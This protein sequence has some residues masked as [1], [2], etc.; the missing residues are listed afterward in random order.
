MNNSFQVY[1]ITN[2]IN[3]KS[4]IGQ[5]IK[6]IKRRWSVHKCIANKKPKHYLHLAIRKYGK[7]AF[8][9][10]VI[11]NA[12][13]KESLNALE[14]S[15]IT[16]HN[17]LAPN[18]YNLR[19]GGAGGM[20]EKKQSE[21]SNKKRSL[22]MRG[23]TYAQGYKHTKEAKETMSLVRKGRIVSDAT[24]K[25][26]SILKKGN[27]NMLGKKHSEASKKKMGLAE[28]GK[29]RSEETKKKMSIARKGMK[30]SAETKRKI[31]LSLMGN[32]YGKGTLGNKHSEETK[33]K[34]SDARKG[35]LNPRSRG[36][37]HTPFGVFSS[38]TEAGNTINCHQATVASRC[39]DPRPRWS[40]WYY[41]KPVKEKRKCL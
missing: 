39:R 11:A 23:N 32:T 29:K 34:L 36:L 7:E 9:I 17:T 4:Y 33:K 20:T 3:R 16:Q 18:G 19:T 21:I 40:Q 41:E 22:A 38:T 12:I 6:G 35:I 31:S 27:T 1:K 14:I 13:R 37:V 30:H 15:L 2:I 26:I 28:R 25:K 5:T 10:E 24:K 8:K